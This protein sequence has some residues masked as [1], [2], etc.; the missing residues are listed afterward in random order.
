MDFLKLYDLAEDESLLTFNPADINV[1]QENYSCDQILEMLEYNEINLNTDFQR[2]SD[3][4]DDE[5]MS[6]FIE[7]LML[8]LPIPPFYFNIVYFEG[9]VEKIHWEVID[10]LQRL[11]A[12]RKFCFGNNNENKLVLQGLDFFTELNGM[13][14][15]K[16]PRH[17][18]RNFKSSQL[19]LHLVYPNT[20]VEIKYRI[21]ER[22]NTTNLK[23]KD[24]EVR[25]ALYQGPIINILKKSVKD[26]LI[27][28]NIKIS[29]DR[30][31]AQEAVLRAISFTCFGYSRYPAKS[32]LKLFLD[33]SI[34]ALSKL[35]INE[36]EGI[37]LSF[38]ANFNFCLDILGPDCFKNKSNG[39]AVFNKG[40]F[41]SLIYASSKLTNQQ[42]KDCFKSQKKIYTKYQD[43]F[44]DDRFIKAI[45]SATSR[46]DNVIYRLDKITDIFK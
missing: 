38:L 25:H 8:K 30:M 12:L 45:S 13:S 11:S 15:E 28:N 34:K 2:S 27:P 3:L 26:I 20:P 31:D 36:I 22:I 10:G 7:S 29:D 9:V 24:Q 33:N 41:D 32:N 4:W 18:I 43:C 14:F 46:Q 17:L 1:K 23:L 42:K 21:F 19:Q 44:N 35:K 5:K 40:L 16:I 39:R 6:K 37:Y